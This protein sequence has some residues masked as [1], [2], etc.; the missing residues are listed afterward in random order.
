MNPAFGT[1]RMNEINILPFEDETPLFYR[2][3]V[4]IR[5]GYRGKKR[6]Q[7]RFFDFTT[8]EEARAKVTILRELY[9]EAAVVCAVPIF[10]NHEARELRF[11]ERQ[12]SFARN[13]PLQARPAE[14]R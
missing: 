9:G 12:Q 14:H 2:V 11:L 4:E 3:G 10:P 13:W 5:A 8:M 7:R 6:T 1:L